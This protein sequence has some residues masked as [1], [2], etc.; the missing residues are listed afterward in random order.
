MKL[1]QRMGLVMLPPAQT[2]TSD[3]QSGTPTPPPPPRVVSETLYRGQSSGRLVRGSSYPVEHAI[4]SECQSGSNARKAR[5]FR[6]RRAR[7]II[8][9]AG[10]FRSEV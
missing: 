3:E 1:V 7:Q 9:S 6:H 10:K 8:G 2:G 4:Q 5:S